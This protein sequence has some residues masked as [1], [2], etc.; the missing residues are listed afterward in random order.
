[1]GAKCT[2]AASGTPSTLTIL[3]SLTSSSAQNL[4]KGQDVLFSAVITGP[5]QHINCYAMCDEIGKF[6]QLWLLGINLT[7]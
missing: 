4:D 2:F 6:S 1:M 3:F 7:E 5:N